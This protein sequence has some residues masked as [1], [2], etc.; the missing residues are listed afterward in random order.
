MN[1]VYDAISDV[2]DLK[3]RLFILSAKRM[4]VP[5]IQDSA[6]MHKILQRLYELTGDQI[7]KFK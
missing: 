6:E 3:E 4:M 1:Y 5:S 2:A 7:Y